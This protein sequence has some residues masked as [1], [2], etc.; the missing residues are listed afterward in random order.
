MNTASFNAFQLNGAGF[1]PVVSEK[2]TTIAAAVVSVTARLRI[3]NSTLC[4]PTA[5]I[6]GALARVRMRQALQTTALASIST[7]GRLRARLVTSLVAQ[8]QVTISV[9]RIRSA[10]SLIARAVTTTQPRVILRQ[11]VASFASALVSVTGKVL[12]RAPTVTTGS[13]SIQTDPTIWPRNDVR[14]PVA[15]VA[16]CAVITRGTV[17]HR[18]QISA[19]ASAQLASKPRLV[20]RSPA[21]TQA[22]ALI[23]ASGDVYTFLPFDEPAPEDRRLLVP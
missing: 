4:Q 7:I 14:V 17:R 23:N 2:V 13:A 20:V 1:A 3:Q 12:V 18:P 19:I 22:S 16:A 8:A 15:V 5:Q 21:Q 11:A 10:V 6:S 9:G